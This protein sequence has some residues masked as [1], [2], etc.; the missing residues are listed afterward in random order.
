MQLGHLNDKTLRDKMPDGALDLQASYSRSA[1]L[2]AN[3][4]L[5]PD[6]RLQLVVGDKESTGSS[7]GG[8]R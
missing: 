2:A 5:R 6:I 8:R 1:I 7:A 3:L 4:L